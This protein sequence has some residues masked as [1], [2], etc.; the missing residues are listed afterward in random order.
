MSPAD[1]EGTNVSKHK[2]KKGKWG[3]VDQWVCTCGFDT[4]REESAREHEK[5]AR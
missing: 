3:T 1:E 4:L 2:M 5:S